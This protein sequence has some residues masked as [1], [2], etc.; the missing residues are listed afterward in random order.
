MLAGQDQKYLGALIVPSKEFV[1]NYA[2][3]NNIVYASY[4]QLLETPEIQM[5]I[6]TEIDRLVNAENG[7]R[8]CEKVFKFIL[9]P[10]SFQ[11]GR[12]LSAKQEMIR[13]KISEIYKAQINKIFA[14][15]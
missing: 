6:R 3:E 5:L 7:F 1:Q 9:V 10:E 2:G 11:V 15:D 12:E 14:E 4:E 13:F 8:P